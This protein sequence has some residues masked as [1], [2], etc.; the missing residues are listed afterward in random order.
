MPTPEIQILICTNERDLESGR[1]SCGRR[2]SLDVYRAFKDLVR[3]RDLRERVLVTRTGCLRHC[4]RGPT[5]VVWPGNLWHGGVGVDDA[6]DLL[7]AALVGEGLERRRMP[8]G[9]WE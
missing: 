2:D 3:E 6:S 9:P 1:P 5:V 7:D 4:S 8:A